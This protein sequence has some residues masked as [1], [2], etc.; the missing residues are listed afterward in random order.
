MGDYESFVQSGSPVTNSSLSQR[1]VCPAG[2]RLSLP[3]E[4][5]NLFGAALSVPWMLYADETKLKKRSGLFLSRDENAVSVLL[6][7]PNIFQCL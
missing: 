5:L 1:A 4:S 6:S 7:V 2:T 3:Q